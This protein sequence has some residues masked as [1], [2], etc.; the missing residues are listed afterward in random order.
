[1]H[2]SRFTLACLATCLLSSATAFAAE[3]TVT[4]KVTSVDADKNSITVGDVDLDVTRKTR[5]TID[6][7]KAK[8][9][10]IEEGQNAKVTYDD[11]LEVATSISIADEPEG[12]DEATAKAMKSF[13]GEW[14]CIA[15]EENGKAQDKSTVKKQNRRVTVKGSSLTVERTGAGD[16]FGSYVG[17]FE[18]DASNGHFDWVGKGPGG[19]LV[20]W[21]GIYELNEDTLKLCFVYQKDGKA[22][23]P[24]EFK[25]MP[26]A[27]PG[28]AHVFFT[29]KRDN[30]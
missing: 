21:I 7:K 14:K 29:F 25:S 2:R 13:Q 24:K 18:I 5:I 20:E 10:D 16:K 12:D 1:M 19:N 9:A 11:E 23:R 3:K 28:M 22:K 4:G 27:E 8:L 30:D 26:P 17:K 6:G 15:G